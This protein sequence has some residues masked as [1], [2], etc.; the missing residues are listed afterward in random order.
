MSLE[1]KSRYGSSQK[2]YGSQSSARFRR[3]IS[4]SETHELMP[5]PLQGT[6]QTVVSTAGISPDSDAESQGSQSRIIR[7][8]RTWTVTETPAGK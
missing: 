4:Q 7:E 6:N 1:G 5:L 2:G 3:G 8:V